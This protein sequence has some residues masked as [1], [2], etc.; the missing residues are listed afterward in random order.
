MLTSSN[1]ASNR[2]LN[3]LW[4]AALVEVR[5]FA[6]ELAQTF[7][8]LHKN[9]LHFVHHG[10]QQMRECC[11]NKLISKHAYTGASTY[12]FF[13]KVY[14]CA[15]KQTY[16][17]L[18]FAFQHFFAVRRTTS[19]AGWRTRYASPPANKQLEKYLV[20]INKQ[21]SVNM[22]ELTVGRSLLRHFVNWFVSERPLRAFNVLF[23]RFPL[24]REDGRVDGDSYI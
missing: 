16:L 24:F 5:T 2:F 1:S 13:N 8:I 7:C 3:I 18:T 9:I 10:Y 15:D 14:A 4:N 23:E 17:A 21:N 6:R 22:Q 12:L 19:S 11:I 20:S